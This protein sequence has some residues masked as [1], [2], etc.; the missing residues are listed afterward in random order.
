MFA[1]IAAE[2]NIICSE[3]GLGDGTA[4]VNCHAA[5]DDAKVQ[6]SFF[7]CLRMSATIPLRRIWWE[8]HSMDSAYNLQHLGKWKMENDA[9]KA[10]LVS[11]PYQRAASTSQGRFG[12]LWNWRKGGQ[13]VWMY[14]TQAQLLWKMANHEREIRR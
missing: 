9:E 1:D 6:S 11:H 4:R 12:A 7:N 3:N 5:W 13:Q 8:C 14:L 10:S 2:L